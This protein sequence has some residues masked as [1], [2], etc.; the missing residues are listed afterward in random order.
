VLA[1]LHTN[2]APGAV[3]RL[4]NM[5]IE[6]FLIASSVTAVVAQRLVRRNCPHCLEPYEPSTEE[7]AFL[8]TVGGAGG[9]EPTED[10]RH[11]VG[12]HFC[13]HTGYLERTGVYELLAV[14]DEVRELIVQRAPH[15]EMRKL[16]LSQG[17][18]TLQEQAVRLVRDGSTTAAEV[19]RSIYVAGV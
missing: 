1:T 7:M 17:M 4:D 14:T 2:D 5:G 6:P 16:A 9:P 18:R 13:A 10:F 3:V 11:G 15:D 12:C 19:M 8:R